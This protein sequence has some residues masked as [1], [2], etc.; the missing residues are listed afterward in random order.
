[1]Q[2]SLQQE[3]QFVQRVTPGVGPLFQPVEERVRDQFIPAVFHCKVEE[4]P[5][6]AITCLPCKQPGTALP[7]PTST[8]ESNFQASASMTSYLVEAMGGGQPFRSVDHMLHMLDTRQ[9]TRKAKVE[10]AEASLAALLEPLP[11]ARSRTLARANVTCWWLSVLPSTVNGTELAPEEFRDACYLRYG[12]TPRDLCNNRK[13]Y[14]GG[15][16]DQIGI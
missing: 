12:L 9:A 2:K 6:R 14:T 11:K 10:A 13:G 15:K 16:I 5:D 1:M 3:W 4:I 7:D 8:S